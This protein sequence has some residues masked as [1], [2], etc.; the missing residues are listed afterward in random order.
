M[1]LRWFAPRS[2]HP[3]LK[4]PSPQPSPLWVEGKRVCLLTSLALRASVNGLLPTLK[5]RRTGTDSPFVLY[6]AHYS[7]HQLPSSAKAA[8]GHALSPRGEEEEMEMNPLSLWVESE[9]ESDMRIKICFLPGRG[10]TLRVR[11]V[12]RCCP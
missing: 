10:T 9:K 6:G 11:V 1:L 3:I 12:S 4:P 2:P 8:D 7:S 5:L